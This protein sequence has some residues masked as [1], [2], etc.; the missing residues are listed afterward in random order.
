MNL[1]QSNLATQNYNAILHTNQPSPPP[2]HLKQF[3][4]NCTYNTFSFKR[5]WKQ[6][7][8]YI[9]SVYFI[10]FIYFM[11]HANAYCFLSILVRSVAR[12]ALLHSEAV[13]P[14]LKLLHLLLLLLKY[15]PQEE[16]HAMLSGSVNDL[17][18]GKQTL[19]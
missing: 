12:H 5:D 18:E 2:F 1:S 8:K 17:T 7:Y 19:G 15:S 9:K 16:V 14:E 3:H 13:T 11:L 4:L 6:I 10:L